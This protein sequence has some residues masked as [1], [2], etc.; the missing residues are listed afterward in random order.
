MR[1]LFFLFAAVLA[2]VACEKEASK[3]S[4]DNPIVVESIV[5]TPATQELLIGESCTL[6]VVVT[7][8]ELADKVEWISTNSDV[9]AV[10]E[11]TV[12]GVASGTAIVMARVGDKT[13]SCTVSVVGVPVESIS[14]DEE[15]L[16]MT[17]GD[18][19]TLRA[20]VLPE[21]ADNKSVTWSSSNE[22]ILTVNG[23]GTVTAVRPGD[24]IVY[25]K[26]GN[27]TAQCE[28]SI[29]QRPLSVGDYY[30]SDGSWSAQ[31]DAGRTPIGVV[32]YVG[33][34]TATDPA[35]KNEHPN[36]VHGLVVS[37]QEDPDGCA[38]QA[39]YE[40]YASTIGTWCDAFA[41]QYESVTSGYELTDNLNRPIGYNNTK[42][43]EL[44]NAAEDNANWQIEPINFVVDYRE[45]VPA[46]E[47]SSD[48]Y[49]P[50]AK[51]LSL[52]MTGEYDGNIWDIRDS[53]A[54]VEN[55]KEVN[56]KIEKVEGAIGIGQALPGVLF[57]YWSSTEVSWEFA[58]TV[59]NFN[60]QTPQAYKKETGWNFNVRPVLAF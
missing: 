6:S 14:L 31:L 35:L 36:C 29:D 48:W 11:G 13:G 2:I 8:A 52:L 60:G 25:A 50:S 34:I 22:D 1:K 55:L 20:T 53:G 33:D 16:Y 23:S 7:P 39:N 15:I 19:R 21:N 32:F 46:P 58:I 54:S 44:F 41:P 10:V 57:F 27:F 45:A 38:W 17:E 42:A 49:L 26:A 37:L 24:A 51:E 18:I 47:T 12:T 59:V 43:M 4:V 28:V 56:K 40:A 3:Q 30:Y 9:A 5:V